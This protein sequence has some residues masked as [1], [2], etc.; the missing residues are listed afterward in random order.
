AFFYPQMA[1]ISLW[2]LCFSREGAKAR[3][4][5]EDKCEEEWRHVLPLCGNLRRRYKD[6]SWHGRVWGGAIQGLCFSREGAKARR[7]QM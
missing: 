6:A 5:E 2:G 7:R 1:Q 4:R 3:R